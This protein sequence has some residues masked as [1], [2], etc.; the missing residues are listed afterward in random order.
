M[1]RQLSIFLENKVGMLSKFADVM[2]ISN[3]ETKGVSVADTTDF[4]ILRAIVLKPEEAVSRF[5]ENGFTASLTNVLAV[6]PKNNLELEEVFDTL[7]E[8]NISIEYLYT[9]MADA[10]TVI[11]KVGD[12][13][14]AEITLGEKGIR[15]LSEDDIWA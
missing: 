7:T 15:L 6:Q 12:V 11:I 8:S 3:F 5:R 1:V 14:K 9:I 2:N 4:G 13:Q 10:L